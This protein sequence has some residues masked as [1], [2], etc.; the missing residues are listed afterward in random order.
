MTA[1]LRV[2]APSPAISIA[3]SCPDGTSC[4]VMTAQSIPDAAGSV[5]LC[6]DRTVME[7]LLPDTAG[8]VPADQLAVLLATTRLVGMRCPGLHSIYS[9]LDLNFSLP[10]AIAAASLAWRVR[11]FDARFAR[12]TIEVSAPG[13]DG[14]VIALMRPEPVTQPCFSD[15]ARQISRQAWSGR[16]ALV[17][18]GSRGL[19]ELCCK[20]LAAGGAELRLT[21]HRDAA[22][23]QKLAAEIAAGGGNA[24]AVAYD[25]LAPPPDLQALLGSGWSPSHLYY[26]A[27]PRIFVGGR[28]GFDHGLL[29]LFR[30]YYVTGLREIVRSIRWLTGGPLTVFYPS[31]VAVESPPLDMREYAAA[32]KA[33]EEACRSLAAT[34][35]TLTMHVE[36]LPRVLTD[37]TATVMPVETAD[38][39]PL[40]LSVLRRG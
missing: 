16:R 9:G 39:I 23:A 28:G 37:Q 25:V 27:T 26:F 12:A 4:A 19:G 32:K 11:R 15:I 35:D 40:L 3:N 38:P 31:S 10:G 34:D 5:E 30:A 20:M 7:R 18:G 13:V 17:I 6:L 1:E 2:D 33:G 14:T 36:R 29:D 21:Y 22:A 8:R 24:R